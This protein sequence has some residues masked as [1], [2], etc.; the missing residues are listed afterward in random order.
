LYGGAAGRFRSSTGRNPP[1]ARADL[2]A[3]KSF[4]QAGSL[5]RRLR[6]VVETILEGNR[7]QLKEVTE[8]LSV[9]ERG[10]RP[11]AGAIN[12]PFLGVMW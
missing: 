6:Y 8:R 2:K 3:A 12:P 11:Y 1:P 7:A 10:R 4:A 5:A 9:F